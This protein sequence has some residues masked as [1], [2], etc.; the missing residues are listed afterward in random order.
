MSA[1]G[2]IY[3]YYFLF[4]DGTDTGSDMI[5]WAFHFTRVTYVNIPVVFAPIVILLAM[6]VVLDSL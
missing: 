4:L 3:D 6:F 1:R 2:Q 5:L